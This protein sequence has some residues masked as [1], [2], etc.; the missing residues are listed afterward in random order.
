M[1]NAARGGNPCCGQEK[2]AA[3][4]RSP[5]APQSPQ[6]GFCGVAKWARF[7]SEQWR[8]EEGLCPPLCSGLVCTR[9]ERRPQKSRWWPPTRRSYLH[10]SGVQPR[11]TLP[12]RRISVKDY[13]LWGRSGKS[14]R[15][16]VPTARHQEMWHNR[17]PQ[18]ILFVQG[19]TT[20]KY[21]QSEM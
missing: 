11:P 12:V 1:G 16:P 14:G 18:V 21:L 2:Q 15:V 3:R 9:K 4:R 6:R 20:L 17:F 7:I 19:K 13:K 8:A 10:S 5:A